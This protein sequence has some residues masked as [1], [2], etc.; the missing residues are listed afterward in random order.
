VTLSGADR[1]AKE[2]AIGG[3]FCVLSRGNSSRGFFLGPE[4]SEISPLSADRDFCLPQTI[5]SEPADTAVSRGR[6]APAR[7]VSVVL[8]LG[9]GAEIRSLVVQAVVIDVVN[10]QTIARLELEDEAM[11]R[12]L[13]LGARAGD[14]RRN[15]AV[16]GLVPAALE[17]AGKVFLIYKRPC[18]DRTVPTAQG[19]ACAHGSMINAWPSQNGFNW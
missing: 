11:Q 18:M 16:G 17:T 3:L 8:G 2:P 5:P 14:M 6:V 1:G 4:P 15:V 12:F 10:V 13:A 7:M 9:A 19:D